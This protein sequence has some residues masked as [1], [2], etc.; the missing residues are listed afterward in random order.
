MLANMF[1]RGSFPVL[2][3]SPINAGAFCMIAGLIIVPIVSLFTPKPDRKV[4]DEAFA[5]Y[6]EKVLVPQ[7]SALGDK[8]R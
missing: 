7:R 1:V 8:D 4:V 6:N 3:Q 5:C 2:L